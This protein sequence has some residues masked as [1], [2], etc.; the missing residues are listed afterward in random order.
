MKPLYFPYTYVPEQVFGV[1]RT[2]FEGIVLYQP[3]EASIPPSI[4]KFADDGAITVRIPVKKLSQELEKALREFTEF[5]VVHG[6]NSAPVLGLFDGGVPFFSDESVASLRSRI[7]TEK[8]APGGRDESLFRTR[9]FLLLAQEHDRQ[10]NR[11]QLDLNRIA[12]METE[13]LAGLCEPDTT[14]KG[15][16]L[17]AGAPP[18][19]G[20]QNY[21]TAERLQ[22]WSRLALKDKDIPDI[23]LTSS[24]D[25]FE[26]FLEASG[27][28]QRL[29]DLKSVSISGAAPDSGERL[30]DFIEE[31]RSGITADP[32]RLTR[33]FAAGAQDSPGDSFTIAVARIPETSGQAYLRFLAKESHPRA[34][35][36]D[37]ATPTGNL[38]VIKIAMQN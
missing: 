35:A 23:L 17:K 33:A 38:V 37:T 12:R 4:Q 29:L 9:L 24:E 5:A 7:R 26:S 3:G 11:V 16:G 2:L 6:D 20:G 10:N 27:N 34:S 1:M 13:M 14:E 30:A 21:M 32:E 25:A 31:A 36:G 19:S 28:A 18:L 15:E 8:E 22:R